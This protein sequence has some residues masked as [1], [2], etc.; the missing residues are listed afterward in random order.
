MYGLELRK[1]PIFG[2]IHLMITFDRRIRPVKILVLRKWENESLVIFVEGEQK[3]R[4]CRGTSRAE[5]D[6]TWMFGEGGPELWHAERSHNRSR[7]KSWDLR[8]SP[9]LGQEEWSLRL[10]YWRHEIYHD[11][12]HHYHHVKFCKSLPL[13]HPLDPWRIA[14]QD[15]NPNSYLSTKLIYFF[16]FSQL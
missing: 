5:V 16:L 14:W 7:R 11:Y 10:F 13:F 4:A 12:H 8:V 1:G 6:E 3:T 9:R 15:L 2:V